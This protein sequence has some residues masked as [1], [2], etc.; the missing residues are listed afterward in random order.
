MQSRVHKLVKL[1]DLLSEFTIL[2]NSI[3][4]FQKSKQLIKIMCFLLQLIKQS[5]YELLRRV[6]VQQPSKLSRHIRLQYFVT[7]VQTHA[8]THANIQVT[9]ILSLFGC[10]KYHG[11]LFLILLFFPHPLQQP[12]SDP[13]KPKMWI[14][15][16]NYV[17]STDVFGDLKTLQLLDS[18]GFLGFTALGLRVG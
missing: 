16:L 13:S 9:G 6:I 5:I 1:F 10:I 17:D 4:S 3:L 12:S 7:L 8:S 2:F 11:K 18:G 14:A 15:F